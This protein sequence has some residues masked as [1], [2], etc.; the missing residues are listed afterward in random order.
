MSTRNIDTKRAAVGRKTNRSRRRGGAGLAA[1]A[2]SAAALAALAPQRASAAS[3]TWDN[4]GGD[5]LWQSVTNWLSDTQFPGAT[6]G[7]ASTDDATFGLT[8]ATGTIDL[9][10]TINVNRLLFGEAGADAASFTIGDADDILNF[11]AGGGITVN[12]GVTTAQTIGTSGTTIN[13]S[14]AAA[15]ATT[16]TNN[17]TGLLTIAGNIVGN[18]ASGNGV[19]HVL[20]S[21]NTAITGTVTEIG[22]GNNALFKRGSGTLTLSNN[23]TWNGTGAVQT[24][25][26][27]PFTVQQGTLLLNAGTHTVTGEAVI[28]GVVTHGGA[29]QNAKIQIDAGA[30]NISSW[31]SVGRG[32]G[33]GTATSDLTLNNGAV[34]TAA[35]ISA[36]FNA[37]NAGNIPKGTI[38]LNGSSS[39]SINNNGAFQLA[40]GTGSNFTMALNGT[41]SVTING[42]G[43]ATNRYIG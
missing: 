6:S 31:L 32:N 43:N 28:G 19:L 24:A 5:N 2:L 16:F 13:L 7:F 37:G 34:V 29:G 9:G 1:A 18:P 39:L 4:G 11:T 22:A 15:A 41:S 23:S 3:D 35:N 42:A 21:G 33:N 36:G 12:A 17:G 20:G 30:L 27:G 25:F 8:G 14:N 10:G 26:S 40:E 38:T